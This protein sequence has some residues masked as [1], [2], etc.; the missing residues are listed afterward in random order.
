[1]GIL[2]YFANLIKNDVTA[3]AIRTDFREKMAINHLL[4][5]FNSIIHTSSQRL[6]NDINIFLELV[7]KSL[8]NHRP[9][10]NIVF[11]E[12][13]Q[14]YKMEHIQKKIN[15]NTDPNV[16]IK[17]FKDFFTD[18]L[19]DKL[20]ITMVINTVLNIVRTYCNN[21]AIK[22]LM[23]AIDGVPSKGKMI[24]QR[25]RRYLGAIQAEYEK[26]I[27]NNYKEYLL[28]Q[29]DYVYLA[30]KDSI[31][32]SKNKIT[33]GTAFMHKLVSY[34]KSE[35]IQ[36]KFKTNRPDMEVIISDMYEIGEGEKKIV[37]YVNEYLVNTEETVV[38]YSPDADMILLCILLHVK[39][40]YM[41]RHNQ[42]TSK[43][44]NIYDLID[45][46]MLKSNISYYIN[47]NPNFS[48]E[49]FDIDRINYDLVCMSTLFGN[50][51]VPKMETLDVA[52]GFQNIM[53]AYL[54]TLLQL[55][56][57]NYYLVKMN[58]NKQRLNLTFL[59]TLLEFLVKDE[60]DFIK[61]ND[62]YAK[63]INLGQIKNVFDYVDI[64]PENLVSVYQE[65]MREYENLKNVIKNNG[66]YTYFLTHDQFMSSLKK[67][68]RVE[69]DGA[70]VNTSYLTNKELVRLLQ[71]YYRKNRE[72]PR[73]TINL[74]T[75][76]HSINDKYHQNKL[77]EAHIT[78]DY[79]KE[80]Y[81]FRNMLDQYY[82]KFN[83]QPLSLT[84]NKIGDYYMEYFGTQLFDEK[85]RLTKDATKVM[86]DYTEGLLWVFDYYFNDPSYINYWYY[87]HERA[88]LM[89]HLLMFLNS[90]DT[91][92][93]N[94]I[95]DS[96]DKYHVDDLKT[97]FNPLEQ[98]IYVSPMTPGIIKLLPVNYQKYITSDKL[99]PFLRLFFIDINEF[100]SRLWKDYVSKDVDC[101]G[102][103][104]LNK[105]NVKSIGKPT[106]SDD[107]QFLKAIRKVEPSE[108]SKRRS[109][110]KEPDY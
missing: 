33:P 73:V 54:K 24:E 102:I 1:M 39:K 98:L 91:E 19:L 80:L 90:I 95:L 67:C 70:T 26:K 20:V 89:R 12:K 92:Y 84:K 63:Y 61:Y 75:R 3:S 18:D 78:N 32:W 58:G 6:V 44:T 101:H 64:N 28:K 22:T 97:Y 41:L 109:K 7:L 105:C 104:F 81:K 43:E 35:K 59:K 8:Y 9:V 87:H 21:K 94:K 68:L 56:V 10:T 60:D 46:R 40:I 76:S 14:K 25:Q 71:D 93:F 51:F 110:N 107:K 17:I 34:L 45:I 77:K 27:F 13:F 16:V 11:T 2:S 31:K 85:N 38:I 79:Q 82:V 15:H 23:L 49:E 52:K 50:D 83:A 36:K 37:N 66:N 108:T 96:L 69:I 62:L 48:K 74:N 53:D 103:P 72:F 88:P 4:M 47:N 42:Q 30:I 57:K 100:V 86:Y 55:K 65:F 106:N 99:D 29:P 5:D